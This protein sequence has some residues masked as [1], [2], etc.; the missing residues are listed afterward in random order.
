MNLVERATIIHFHR[1]RIARHGCEA[2]EALGWRNAQS[3]QQ[4]FEVIAAAADFDRCF[5][6][7]IGCG[8]GDLAPFLDQRFRDMDYIGINV[9]AF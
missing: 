2:V 9:F 8:G 1:R 4:H 7:D 5:V 3:Q 6:F